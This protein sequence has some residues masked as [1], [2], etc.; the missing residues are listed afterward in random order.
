MFFFILLFC[1]AEA[2][3]VLFLCYCYC[4]VIVLCYC[5]VSCYSCYGRVQY[6]GSE[7]VF[8]M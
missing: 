8:L 3:I 4:H 1:I 6:S 2:G 5:Y 7:P